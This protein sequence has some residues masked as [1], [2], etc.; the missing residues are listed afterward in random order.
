MG[1]SGSLRGSLATEWGGSIKPK[2]RLP[3]ATVLNSEPPLQATQNGLIPEACE[4][5]PRPCKSTS[6]S[7]SMI[8][9]TT[10]AHRAVNR[11]TIWSMLYSRIASRIDVKVVASL[12]RSAYLTQ[13][14]RRFAPD[15]TWR[16]SSGQPACTPN[17]S[18]QVLWHP[19][20]TNRVPP[21]TCSGSWSLQESGRS[22]SSVVSLPPTN[23]PTNSRTGTAYA[24]A[25]SSSNGCTARAGPRPGRPLRSDMAAPVRRP[26]PVAAA[27]HRPGRWHHRE[28]PRTSP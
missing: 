10:I 2:E 6:Q 15:A 3:R 11:R 19:P 22:L 1:A 5:T 7:V 13:P 25:G 16:S 20:G 26:V 28:P 17:R 9:S 14:C 23:A 27:Q 21:N 24:A 4:P 8:S 12:L 18:N